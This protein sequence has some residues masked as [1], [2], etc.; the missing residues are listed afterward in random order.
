M[1]AAD[2]RIIE[3]NPAHQPQS[4]NG[5]TLCVRGHFA[6]DFLNSSNRLVGPLLRKSNDDNEESLVPITWDEALGSQQRLG[7]E[8]YE[9][10]DVPEPEVAIPGVT[11][12][13]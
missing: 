1:G 8:R 7:P 2:D 6:H 3:V 12:F 10:G 11:K 4:V 5:A 13:V 9:W